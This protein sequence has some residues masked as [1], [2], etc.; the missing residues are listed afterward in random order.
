MICDICQKEVEART[1]RH[2]NEEECRLSHRPGTARSKPEWGLCDQCYR[3]HILQI[4]ANK[5]DR[6]IYEWESHSDEVRALNLADEVICYMADALPKVKTW[7][8][9]FDESA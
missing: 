6:A 5:L 8:K 7:V 4:A 9:F 1:I 3:V 2:L